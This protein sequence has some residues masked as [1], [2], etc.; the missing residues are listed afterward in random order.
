MKKTLTNHH[1]RPDYEII[2]DWITAG[3]EVL[4]LGCGDGELLR[5]LAERKGVTGYGVEIDPG[6]IPQC[7]ENGINVIQTNLNR[8]LAGI[9]DGSFDYVVLSLTL[10]AMKD[11]A[12]LLDEMLRVGNTGIVSFPN[13]GHWKVRL[14]L[15][16]MGH[17]PVSE[18]LPNAWNNT[19][20]IHLCTLHDFEDLCTRKGITILERRAA[21]HAHQTSLGLRLLPNILG[22]IAL[23]RFTR[24]T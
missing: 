3:S 14:Q 23:Y 8:G 22:E 20:N 11:P 19:P 2:T 21:D 12:I 1:L 24:K 15:G 5:E 18:A 13:F 4:D 17:M 9:N 10:Q 16:I 6:Y 7:I